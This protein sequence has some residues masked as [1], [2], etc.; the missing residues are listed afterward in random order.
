MQIGDELYP[1]TS[2][3]AVKLDDSSNPSK[4]DND[5]ED[6]EDIEAQIARELG[7]LQPKTAREKRAMRFNSVKTDCEC[8]AST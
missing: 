2:T 7:E 6:E 3:S 8:R 4:N 1:E 5:D